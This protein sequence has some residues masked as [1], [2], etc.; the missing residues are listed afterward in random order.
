MCVSRLLN[1]VGCNLRALEVLGTLL[2]LDQLGF[3]IDL[4]NLFSGIACLRAN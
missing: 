2:P 1:I 3:L 4:I